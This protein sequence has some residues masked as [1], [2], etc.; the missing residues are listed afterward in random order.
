MSQ[1]A[2]DNSVVCSGRKVFVSYQINGSFNTDNKLLLEYK[3]GSNN[4][5]WQSIAFRD[6]TNTLIA[7]L[8]S[9]NQL[10]IAGESSMISFRIR[11]TSP[12]LTSNSSLTWLSG[13][14]LV[15]LL[16][17]SKY[18]AFPTETVSATLRVEGMFTVDATFSNGQFFTLEGNAE[19]S[20]K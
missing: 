1:G 18:Q 20:K 13:Q 2:K 17:L 16:G 8:P 6:S 9:I 12:A 10:R 11:S 4:T 14:P 3:I 7:D 15:E 19:F 5:N